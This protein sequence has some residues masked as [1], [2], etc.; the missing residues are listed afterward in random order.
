MTSVKLKLA[1]HLASSHKHHIHNT[2]NSNDDGALETSG[3]TASVESYTMIYNN[4]TIIL[5][6]DK[7]SADELVLDPIMDRLMTIYAI[8]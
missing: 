1:F 8:L 6:D 4:Y 2:T 7:P 5:D 3:D